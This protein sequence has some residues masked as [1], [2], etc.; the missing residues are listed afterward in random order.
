M[1][2]VTKLC[3]LACLIVPGV[4]NAALLNPVFQDHAVLQRDKPINVWGDASPS[5]TLSVS[6]GS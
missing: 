3:T 1:H 5:E 4:D 6:L 2:P